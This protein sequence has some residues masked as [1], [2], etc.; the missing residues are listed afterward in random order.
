[1]GSRNMQCNCI[2]AMRAY[3]EQIVPGVHGPEGSKQIVYRMADGCVVATYDGGNVT[4]Q[5]V[6]TSP[7]V[8]KVT[9]V[10]AALNA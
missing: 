10:N 5:G 7:W 6:A 3:L 1:M 8:K 9:D 2:N 4:F